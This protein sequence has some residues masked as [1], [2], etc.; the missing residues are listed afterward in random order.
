M[1]TLPGQCVI[2]STAGISFF[3]QPTTSLR[4]TG[5]WA[6]GGAV[7]TIMTQSKTKASWLL[8]LGLC[9][10]LSAIG[11]LTGGCLCEALWQGVAAGIC[12]LAIEWGHFQEVSADPVEE[13]PHDK[14]LDE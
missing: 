6:G 7:D 9:L 12:G 13:L 3:F 8:L 4:P 1:L 14:W 10:A 5:W 11:N 2:D